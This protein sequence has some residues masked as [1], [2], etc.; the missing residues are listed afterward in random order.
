MVLELGAL[1]IYNRIKKFLTHVWGG[2]GP[3]GGGMGHFTKL[4]LKNSNNLYFVMK[5]IHI[6]IYILTYL[7]TY[8]ILKHFDN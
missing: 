6:M 8:F 2:N 7:L 3:G 5:F 4:T 1:V